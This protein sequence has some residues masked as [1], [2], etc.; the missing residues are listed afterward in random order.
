[1]PKPDFEKEPTYTPFEQACLARSKQFAETMPP[2]ALIQSTKPLTFGLAMHDSPFGM[3][4][5][6]TDKLPPWTDDYAWTPTELITWTLLHYF[7]GPTTGF[8]M[9]HENL[10][11]EDMKDMM[12]AKDY[13]KAPTGV[14]AF[15]KELA[16]VPRSWA[17]TRSNVVFWRE[18]E[19]GGHFAAWEKPEELVEDLVEFYGSVWK[20]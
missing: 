3:L 11:P 15:A 16:L 4:A 1:M 18:H 12:Q 5:W 14:S 6:M 7:P 8:N 17:E 10:K 13:V 9:Y 20:D 19:R 2:H